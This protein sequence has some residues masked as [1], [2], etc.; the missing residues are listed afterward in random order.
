MGTF[1]DTGSVKP[2]SNFVARPFVFES[3]PEAT[4]NSLPDT[5]LA[6]TPLSPASYG[7]T[8]IASP[9]NHGGY[10]QDLY[11]GFGQPQKVGGPGTLQGVP[12]PRVL[13][14]AR[15]PDSVLD[16]HSSRRHV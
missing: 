13:Q 9:S 10:P 1:R 14:T 3:Q 16:D 11:G 7:D 5:N 4:N 15:K 2:R 8:S 12:G 6:A